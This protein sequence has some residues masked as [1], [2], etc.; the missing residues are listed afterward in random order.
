MLGLAGGTLL[1]AGNAS[2]ASARTA[3]PEA[4]GEK[5]K[6]GVEEVSPPEDLMRE[7]G[8]LNRILLVYEEGLRRL[9]A[10]QT[11]PIEALATAADIIRRFIEE[12]HEKLEED[13]LFPRFEQANILVDLVT[14]L[15]QQHAAGR[16][17]TASILR[18][19]NANSI[20]NAG[21]RQQLVNAMRGFIR[22]YRPHE[23]REDTVLF[24]A[25]RH[26]VAAK[27]FAAM[28]ERFEDTEHQRF[29]KAG[30]DG[31]VLQVAQIEETLGIYD[32]NQFTPSV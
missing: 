8:V 16:V 31:I 30:F 13:Q 29:G 19:A 7:H 3:R 5:T 10:Q 12:Y 2:L 26:V 24:P 15:R 18:L 32:L 21:D 4:H 11:L 14:T 23:A 9:E 27:E 20:Q 17:L 22:M 25:V 28:G 1:L 6:E